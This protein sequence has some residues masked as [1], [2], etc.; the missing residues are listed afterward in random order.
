MALNLP[1]GKVIDEFHELF[2][3]REIGLAD[4]LDEHEVPYQCFWSRDN[5]S[6]RENGVYFVTVPSLNLQ[7]S[8]HQIL[9]VFE[10]ELFWVI[11]PNN[12]KDGKLYYAHGDAAGEDE[13]K[14]QAFIL[15]FFI[16]AEY[17]RESKESQMVAS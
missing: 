6:I 14:L 7:A 1:I 8:N 4:Y 10:N 9:C 11:D 17:Y 2:H 12:G 16:P 15:D 5:H 13:V 3:K